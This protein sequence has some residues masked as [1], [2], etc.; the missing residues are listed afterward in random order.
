[1]SLSVLYIKRKYQVKKMLNIE[2][3][4]DQELVLKMCIPK[5]GFI[6]FHPLL[7]IHAVFMASMAFAP[8]ILATHIAVEWSLVL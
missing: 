1:M 5:Y 4:E 6:H 3:I 2:N 8:M 7:F